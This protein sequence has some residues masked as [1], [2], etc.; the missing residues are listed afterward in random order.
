MNDQ[1]IR[2]LKGQSK[3]P[4]WFSSVFK[5]IKNPQSGSLVIQLTD[6]RKF[7]VESQKPGANAFIIVRNENLFS[8]LVREGQNGFSEAY[9]DGW[10]DT[11]NLQ[12]VLDF[13]LLAGD[14]LYND[15]IG[16]NFV[17][18]VSYTHLTLPTTPYV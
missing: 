7:F 8:R 5:M 2:D 15:L 16:T 14:D 4:R 6:G 11:P 9:M 3:L 10:W 13:F 12:A 1:F 18:A 17:R